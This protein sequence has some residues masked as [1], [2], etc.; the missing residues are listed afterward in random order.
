MSTKTTFDI[1]HIFK[2]ISAPLDNRPKKKKYRQEKIQVIPSHFL[3]NNLKSYQHDWQEPLCFYNSVESM[4]DLSLSSD[5]TKTR[6]KIVKAL[7]TVKHY[8]TVPTEQWTTY[9]N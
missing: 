5:P 9:H 2:L 3:V 8:S 1:L 6:T 7:A 4:A